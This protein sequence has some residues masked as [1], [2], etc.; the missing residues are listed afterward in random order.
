[1]EQ[2]GAIFH[3]VIGVGTAPVVKFLIW[4]GAMDNL[5]LKRM[6]LTQAAGVE[7]MGAI[8]VSNDAHV[9]PIVDG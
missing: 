3:H 1:M 6:N 4:Q 8:I 5:N 9:H 2:Y 7:G